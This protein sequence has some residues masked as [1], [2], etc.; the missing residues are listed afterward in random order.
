[1]D[2]FK[3]AL[4]G[5]L[6]SVLTS[7]VLLQLLFSILV[8]QRLQFSTKQ[9]KVNVVIFIGLILFI[10]AFNVANL[11]RTEKLFTLSDDSRIFYFSYGIQIVFLIWF[12]STFIEKFKILR[13]GGLHQV[14]R[15]FGVSAMSIL[16]VL[17]S[18]SN[19]GPI[20][21]SLLV[22]SPSNMN[23]IIVHCTIGIFALGLILPISLILWFVP[24]VYSKWEQK[25]WWKIVQITASLLF[26][27]KPIISFYLLLINNQGFN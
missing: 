10:Y 20:L 14:F 1:M 26:L 11:I 22:T 24:K 5:G 12:L 21:S 19:F 8:F 23:P 4:I 16:L 27:I 3:I 15:F 17:V 13:Q 9:H 6:L 25:R 7:G 2:I 18:F